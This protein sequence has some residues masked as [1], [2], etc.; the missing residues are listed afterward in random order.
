MAVRIKA[1]HVGQIADLPCLAGLETC[2][3]S[4]RNR[5]EGIAG[6]TGVKR[7]S[8]LRTGFDTLLF[9]TY[10]FEAF[11][12]DMSCFLEVSVDVP[13]LTSVMGTLTVVAT[14]Y[15]AGRSNLPPAKKVDCQGTSSPIRSCPP[16]WSN[17]W[18]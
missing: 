4:F 17:E 7:F 8:G 16:Y 10:T 9:E 15:W 6:R 18:I 13:F 5:F 11:C 14:Y 12:A 3:T 2:P 1:Q